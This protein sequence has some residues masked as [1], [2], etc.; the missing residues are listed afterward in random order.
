MSEQ[1]LG[2]KVKIDIIQDA[3][4]IELIDIKSGKE[5]YV[6]GGMQSFIFDIMIK[7]AICSTST[8]GRPNILIVDEQ[9]S[10]LDQQH[11]ENINEIFDYLRRNYDY[12]IMISHIN[13]VKEYVNTNLHIAKIKYNDK[14]YSQI[15]NN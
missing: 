3:I 11:R 1:Y 7:S 12:T 8:L 5:I 13:E 14:E 4:N 15:N 6:L 9:I 2:I 10:A